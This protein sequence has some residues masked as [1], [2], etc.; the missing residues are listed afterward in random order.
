MTAA[1]YEAR[2]SRQA[3]FYQRYNAFGLSHDSVRPRDQRV[4]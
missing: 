3:L 2:F 1:K 4:E